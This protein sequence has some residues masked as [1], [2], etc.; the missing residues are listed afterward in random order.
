ME[1]RMRTILL[2]LIFCVLV[3]FL[4]LDLRKPSA[5]GRFVL[6]PEDSPYFNGSRDAVVFDSQTGQVCRTNTIFVVKAAERYPL[7]SD[8]AKK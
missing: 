6:L 1:N 2:A 5:P 4:W 7:C 8:L 3:A